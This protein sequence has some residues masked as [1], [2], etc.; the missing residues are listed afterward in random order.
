MFKKKQKQ[1]EKNWYLKKKN[2]CKKKSMFNYAT[3]FFL[4]FLL[5]TP[6]EREKSD[7]LKFEK[8]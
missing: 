6:F 5:V 1:N 3:S 8:I 4:S 2:L 7:C